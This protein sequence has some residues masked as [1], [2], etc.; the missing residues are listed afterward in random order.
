M[1]KIIWSAGSADNPSWSRWKGEESSLVG[2][3][4]ETAAVYHLLQVTRSLDSL[5]IVGGEGSTISG[6][7]AMRLSELIAS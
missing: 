1:P 3:N 2:G 6:Q 7:E 4:L 5:E